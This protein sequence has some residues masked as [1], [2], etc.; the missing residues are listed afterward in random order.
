MQAIYLLVSALGINTCRKGRKWDW[1]EGEIGLLRSHNASANSDG[2]S[3]K[4][5]FNILPSREQVFYLSI[6]HTCHFLLNQYNLCN[7]INI[8]DRYRVML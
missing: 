1:T 4:W 8:A 3:E 6:S 5:F 7:V 2:N